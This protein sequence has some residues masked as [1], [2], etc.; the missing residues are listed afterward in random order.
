MLF[1]STT[2]EECEE[3]LK[4]LIAETK[5]EIAEIKA[6]EKATNKGWL[7]RSALKNCAAAG[8]EKAFR[9]KKA[10]CAVTMAQAVFMPSGEFA[11]VV[12]KSRL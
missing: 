8:K 1:Y 3:K 7:P 2:L 11:E 9:K 12:D 4:V 5:K 6:R 10:A